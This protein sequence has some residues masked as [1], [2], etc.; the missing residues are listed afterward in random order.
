MWVN[1][2]FVLVIVEL[3]EK[4]GIWPCN[5]FM[6]PKQS[7]SNN[8][9]VLFYL[10]IVTMLLDIMEIGIANRQKPNKIMIAWGITKLKNRD[11]E[12]YSHLHF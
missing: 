7:F 9:I 1:T 11:R 3:S 12:T 5:I 2:N 8:I 10:N 4:F 6:T